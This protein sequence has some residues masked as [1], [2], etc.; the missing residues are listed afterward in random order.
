M[1]FLRLRRGAAPSWR[2]KQ[3]RG[4]LVHVKEQAGLDAKGFP[5]QLRNR[6][7]VP[8]VVWDSLSADITTSIAAVPNSITVKYLA[9]T[10]ASRKLEHTRIKFLMTEQPKDFQQ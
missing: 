3:N 10:S 5:F 9:T 8:A 1:K 6:N 7:C 2:T 4:T